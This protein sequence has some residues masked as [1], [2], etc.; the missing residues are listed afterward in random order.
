M[1]VIK[2]L[3]APAAVGE[4]VSRLISFLI[5][6]YAKQTCSKEEMF[7]QLEL[8]ALKIHALVEEAERRH[9]AHNRRLLLWLS[10]LMEGMY[11]AYYVLD[12][13]H[14]GSLL[15][16]SSWSFSLS[17]SSRPAKRLCT[18]NAP[19]PIC[20]ADANGVVEELSATLRRLEECAEGM[21]E[22][23]LL[24]CMLPYYTPAACCLQLSI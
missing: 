15:V 8:V 5:S 14:D 9:L 13:R 17:R 3:V 24:L 22:F 7:L 21:K 1:K 16:S 23:I 18:S 19:Q 4:L 12:H 6:R 20:A 11:R 2:E 10:K